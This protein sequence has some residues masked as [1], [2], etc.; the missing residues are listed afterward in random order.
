LAV[1]REFVMGDAQG[2]H[3]RA[4][5]PALIELNEGIEDALVILG[6]V[7]RGDNEGPGL[8]SVGGSR[9]AGRFE[10]AAQFFGLDELAVESARAPSVPDYFMNRRGGWRRPLWCGHGSSPVG[11]SD[12]PVDAGS[13]AKD[14]RTSLR[15]HQ[16]FGRTRTR[17]EILQRA[18][19]ARFRTAIRID[20][21]LRSVLHAATLDNLQPP[22]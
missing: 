10:K 5:G 19:A 20:R 2:D 3:G 22:V 12:H 17:R 16:I 1:V 8:C 13:R 21:R 6:I 4:L 18:T 15:R 11:K 7:L 14:S 9:P